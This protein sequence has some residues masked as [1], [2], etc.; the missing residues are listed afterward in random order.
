MQGAQALRKA[1]QRLPAAR[2]G[3]ENQAGCQDLP[4]LRLLAQPAILSLLIRKNKTM[5]V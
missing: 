3:E 4:G 5:G 1:N 2:S